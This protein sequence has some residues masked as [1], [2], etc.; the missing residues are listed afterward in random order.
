M[1]LRGRK[2]AGEVAKAY[3]LVVGDTFVRG[4]VSATLEGARKLAKKTALARGEV[5]SVALGRDVV[6]AFGADGE[7]MRPSYTLRVAGHLLAGTFTADEAE[8]ESVR[9]AK[10]APAV[11]ICDVWGE[12][13]ARVRDG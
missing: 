12:P 9:L 3:R 10:A 5:V 8:R 2:G 4:A 1:G 6:E 11:E 13:L 7:P